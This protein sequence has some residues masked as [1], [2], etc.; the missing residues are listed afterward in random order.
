MSFTTDDRV[1]AIPLDRYERDNLVALL[2]AVAKGTEY[3]NPFGS[4]NTGDW[5]L[6][7]L[8][9]L[10]RR[11]NSIYLEDGDRPNRSVEDMMKDAKNRARS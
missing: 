9:K 3:G 10:R 2:T 1:W 5:V 11:D 4:A 7:I 8:G 6:Q